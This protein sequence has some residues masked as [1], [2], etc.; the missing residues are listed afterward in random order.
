MIWDL[1]TPDWLSST[2]VWAAGALVVVFGAWMAGK[3]GGRQKAKT[4]V[5]RGNVET[6]EKM[7]DADI[8]GDDPDM[9]RKW[10][11][12]RDADKR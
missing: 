12:E 3:R 2:L 9:A 1:I 6:R 7:D 11:S 10:L 8:V 4:E 5:L